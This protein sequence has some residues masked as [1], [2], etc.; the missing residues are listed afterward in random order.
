[1]VTLTRRQARPVPLVQGNGKKRWFVLKIHISGHDNYCLSYYHSP[2]EK[3]PRQQY[4][5]DGATL[6]VTSGSNSNNSFQV[7]CDD[8]SH[9]MIGCD[10]KD[11]MSKWIL[12]LETAI[13]V[14]SDR[15]E[16]N[17]RDGVVE[18]PTLEFNLNYPML[19]PLHLTWRTTRC[20][21]MM[22]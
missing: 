10:T 14:A 18:V 3:T 8:G 6:T 12:S 2:E 1:M 16:F 5:L 7:I 20:L 21:N 22:K 15:G 9:V 13:R 19:N 4:K 11:T 17:V